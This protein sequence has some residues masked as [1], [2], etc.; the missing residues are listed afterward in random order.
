MVSTVAGIIG[1]SN[2]STTNSSSNRNRGITSFA[3]EL[4]TSYSSIHKVATS[5]EVQNGKLAS[6]VAEKQALTDAANTPS[7]A[8][9]TVARAR[10]AS[11]LSEAQNS[12][13]DANGI[14]TAANTNTNS[15]AVSDYNTT[16][17]TANNT[18]NGNFDYSQAG[19]TTSDSIAN[20]AKETKKNILSQEDF[21]KL[22][23][24]QLQAQDP[25]NPTDNNQLVTQMSQLSMVESLNSI[26][27]NMA[28]VISTVNS[29]SALNATSLIGTY[30][31]TDDAQT[32]FDGSSGVKWSIDA[33][34]ETYSD[35]TIQIKD[36]STGQVVY[37]DH[38]D[39]ISGE[40]KYA[41]PGLYSPDGPIQ[42]PSGSGSDSGVEG[43]DGGETGGIEGGGETG[44]NNGENATRKVS[45]REGTNEGGEEGEGSG[46]GES[47]GINNPY[48]DPDKPGIDI[49]NDGKIDYNYAPAGKYIIEVTGV[50]SKGNTV[51][52]AGKALALVTSVTLGKTTEDTMLSLYGHGSISFAK[53]QKV[54]I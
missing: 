48:L 31:Y 25:T 22:L 16:Q 35:V 38:A 10:A 12:S 32:L 2:Y 52:L 30:V 34:D 53:A 8:S 13:N 28:N 41:W 15:R 49:D 6:T 39:V 46:D 11:A 45:T 3:D 26:N 1:S 7:S 54:T 37:K 40:I 36:A 43:G 24:T 17:S 47:G 29:T 18:N 4:G 14:A 19:V 50:N 27:D 33:G 23:T 21:L 20:A 42:I 5:N 44:E 51:N 9:Y